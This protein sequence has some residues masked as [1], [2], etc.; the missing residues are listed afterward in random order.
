MDRI[1]SLPMPMLLY[2]TAWKKERTA[3]LV[4]QALRCG[5]RGIDTACQPKHYHEPG[6]GAGMAAFAQGKLSRSELYLQ[7]KFTSLSGQDP[8][9]LPYDPD[10][11]LAEQVTESLHSSLRNLGTEYLDCLL[12][13][14]PMPTIP[15]TLE[16]WQAMEELVEQGKVLS[17][18]ISNCYNPRLLEYLCA[19]VRIKPQVLQNR[20][21]AATGYDRII[22]AFCVEN[23]IRYQSFWTLT[24]NPDLL[25]HPLMAGLAERYGKSRAQILFRYL[26]QV[27]VTPL[28]G[29][30]SQRHMQEDLEIFSFQLREEECRE[31]S[32][33]L[34]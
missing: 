17:L 33:L 12:L 8:Q 15:Q 3:Q 7:S 16:V 32:Q 13:H 10:A 22:R 27:G 28:T 9:R 20:F 18:G 34:A 11:E 1:S 25:G 26:T 29:T 2:G 5:F 23:T 30:T 14:S 19:T 31:V 4:E 24:A 21:Y 6:V